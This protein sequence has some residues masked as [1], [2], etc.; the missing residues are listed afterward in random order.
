MI[1]C[2]RLLFPFA[3]EII[4]TSVRMAGSPADAGPVD[5]VACTARTGAA[6][7]RTAGKS[8]LA[9][10]RS[11]SFIFARILIATV[12]TFANTHYP[13][14]RKSFQIGLSP[15]GDK[16]RCARRSPR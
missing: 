5:F 16:G 3:R 14:L 12:P 4:A 1:E 7:R 13:A 15:S 11:F 10:R 8:S 6:G 2:P 9:N